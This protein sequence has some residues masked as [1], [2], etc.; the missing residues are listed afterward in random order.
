MIYKIIDIVYITGGLVLIMVV[1]MAM[2]S[3]SSTKTCC[4]KTIEEVYK[5][6]GLRVNE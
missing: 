6:E 1:I 5:H 2:S 4:E 3:C